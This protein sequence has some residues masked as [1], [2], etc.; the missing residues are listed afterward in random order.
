MESS[1]D[2]FELMIETHI[3]GDLFAAWT[4]QAQTDHDVIRRATVSNY[5]MFGIETVRV[6]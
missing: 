1:T 5:I 4:D 6:Q 3:F 2:E